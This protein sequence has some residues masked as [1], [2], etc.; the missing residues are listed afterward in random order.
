MFLWTLDFGKLRAI[1]INMAKIHK[2]LVKRETS[3]VLSSRI[4]PND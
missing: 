4:V 1:I 2:L 3:G